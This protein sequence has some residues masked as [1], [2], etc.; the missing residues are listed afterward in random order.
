MP[1]LLQRPSQRKAGNTTATV[2][3]S[4]ETVPQEVLLLMVRTFQPAGFMG[5]LFYYRRE[6]LSLVP[7]G[8]TCR[9]WFAMCAPRLYHCIF[10]KHFR[11]DALIQ[12]V[13]KPGSHL[14]Q[15]AFKLFI[16]RSLPWSEFAKLFILRTLPHLRDV[17]SGTQKP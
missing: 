14:A 10:L 8:L 11:T 7:M 2:L 9:A 5:P 13:C 15:H 3:R 1:R 16:N 6:R 4:G 12:D 17:A